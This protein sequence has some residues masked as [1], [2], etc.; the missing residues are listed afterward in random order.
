MEKQ[1]DY[2]NPE[3]YKAKAWGMGKSRKARFRTKA[4]RK[5]KDYANAGTAR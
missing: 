5:S 3:R 1:Y 4:Y 2:E